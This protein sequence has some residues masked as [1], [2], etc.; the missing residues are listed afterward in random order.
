[1]RRQ[2]LIALTILAAAALVSLAGAAVAR[3]DTS[4]PCDAAP[5]SQPFAPW[6]DLSWYSLL[7]NGGFEQGATSWTLGGSAQ[8][9][10]GNEPFQVNDSGDSSSLALG[11]SGKATS[12]PMCVTPDDPT[13]RLFVQNDGDPSSRLKVQVK[14]TDLNNT[15]VTVTVATLA[16]GS[17]W[18]PSDLI[19]VIA[20]QL[21]PV[22]DA[23]PTDV[24][25]R[26]AASN[27]GGDWSIDDVYLDPFKTK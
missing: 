13:L 23:G 14:F 15:K 10:D 26:F 25:F 11:P 27:D 6:G 24:S 8:V 9:V 12:D 21:A 3:A 19:P 16:A 2:T 4:T 1:M 5:V 18:Q 7:P 22:L 17:D 20:A